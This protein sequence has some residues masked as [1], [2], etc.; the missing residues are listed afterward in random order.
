MLM[1]PRGQGDGL[2]NRYRQFNSDHEL[3]RAYRN[4]YNGVV[5]KTIVTDGTCHGRSNRPARVRL[6]SAQIAGSTSGHCPAKI[7]MIWVLLTV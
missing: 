5:L 4:G 2:Q 1:Y 6:G 7:K 3:M